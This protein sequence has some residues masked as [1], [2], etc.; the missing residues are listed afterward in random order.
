VL[1]DEFLFALVVVAAGG[2]GMK[3]S[4]DVLKCMHM[5]EERREGG[6]R[7]GREGGEG[8]GGVVLTASGGCRTP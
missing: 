8:G 6:E 4:R 2:I 3:L 7:G 5:R 1:L